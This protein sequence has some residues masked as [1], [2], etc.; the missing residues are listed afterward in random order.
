MKKRFGVPDIGPAP[1]PKQKVRGLS[2]PKPRQLNP[3]E[4][5]MYSADNA[6][7]PPEHQADVSLAWRERCIS[8]MRSTMN[9]LADALSLATAGG[10][11]GLMGWWDGANEVK[12]D[13]LVEEWRNGTAPSIGV[14]PSVVRE[15]FQ[16]VFND[17]G[18]QVHKAVKDPRGWFRVNKTAYPTIALALTGS[19]SAAY[20]WRGA[21]YLM[22][23]ALAGVGYLAGSM[24]RDMAYQSGIAKQDAL[25]GGSIET[26]TEQGG[27]GN[28]YRGYP[29]SANVA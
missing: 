20:G 10:Y 21:R 15:P 24:F 5:A 23:P 16:D 18:A 3:S 2:M 9:P 1:K 12:R 6:T 8:V 4:T 17:Q 22:A 19:V 26:D 27:E 11:M 29:R 14:D 28:P 13:G 7:L 25:A